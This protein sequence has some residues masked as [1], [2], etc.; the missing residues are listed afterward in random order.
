[1]VCTIKRN[2]FVA[3]HVISRSEITLIYNLHTKQ[4]NKQPILP[5]K[6]IIPSLS[7]SAEL[8]NS[9]TLFKSYCSFLKA[10]AR[11]SSSN[12][13]TPSLFVS[14]SI[15]DAL[16]RSQFK[17]ICRNVSFIRRMYSSNPMLPSSSKCKKKLLSVYSRILEML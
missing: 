4:T 6:L 10:K 5:L 16:Y 8:N 1:M 15:K 11:T 7:V 12:E 17:S 2:A 14:I 3:K 9:R 13:I